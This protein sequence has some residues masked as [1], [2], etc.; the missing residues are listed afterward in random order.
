MLQSFTESIFNKFV[1]IPLLFTFSLS[2]E[3]VNGKNS[4]TNLG[5][6]RALNLMQQVSDGQVLELQRKMRLQ[7][8]SNVEGKRT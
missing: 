4:E 2:N 7:Q 6:M 8:T 5:E 3:D 1:L